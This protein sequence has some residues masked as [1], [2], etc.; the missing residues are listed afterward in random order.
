MT[1]TPPPT[2][3]PSGKPVVTKKVTAN[4]YKLLTKFLE[5]LR[6]TNGYVRKRG[7]LKNFPDEVLDS[8]IEVIV[9]MAELNLPVNAKTKVFF[10]RHKKPISKLF[11]AKHKK[12]ARRKI[13]KEQSGGFVSGLIPILLGA[14]TSL[15]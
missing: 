6:E 9:N 8:L 10:N 15:F 3:Q 14:I 5:V 2:T 7:L 12:L 4:S 11:A 1:T 13:I